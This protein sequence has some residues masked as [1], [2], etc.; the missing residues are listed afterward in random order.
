[1]SDRYFIVNPHGAV[2]EVSKEHAEERI[3]SDPRWRMATKAEV[4][5]YLAAD[6]QTADTPL[7][8]P[9]A[10]KTTRRVT[11]KPNG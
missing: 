10:P 5:A 2:H 3:N 1:M 9:W 7:A 8:T 11:V 6:Q 4:D